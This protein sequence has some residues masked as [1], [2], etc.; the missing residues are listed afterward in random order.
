MPAWIPGPDKAKPKGIAALIVSS[1]SPTMSG[2][3]AQGS[4]DNLRDMDRAR[5]EGFR[6]D[7]D[8]AGAVAARGFLEAMKNGS[9]QDIYRAYKALHQICDAALEAEEGEEGEY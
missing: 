1:R 3:L 9:P 2:E 5:P 7:Y 8:E 6:A 4:A